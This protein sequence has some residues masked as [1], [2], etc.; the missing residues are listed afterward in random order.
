MPP[1]IYVRD[2][3]MEVF[4]NM[5]GED[6]C[7]TSRDGKKWIIENADLLGPLTRGYKCENWPRTNITP[8]LIPEHTSSEANNVLTQRADSDTPQPP[9]LFG[10]KISM[11]RMICIIKVRH[12]TPEDRARKAQERA[13]AEAARRALI[14][15]QDREYAA[16]EAIDRER[17]M[18]AEVDRQNEAER[19]LAVLENAAMAS[20]D[21][22]IPLTLLELR[23][24]RLNAFQNGNNN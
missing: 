20:E 7:Y 3:L 9:R 13:A 21:V 4:S 23:Q 10:Y 17:R 8:Q 24:A 11:N 12:N 5:G 19:V 18:Q 1:T 22:V 2:F 16:A 6:V 15:A 14:E